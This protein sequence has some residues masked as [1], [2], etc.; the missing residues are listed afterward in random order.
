MFLVKP[1]KKIKIEIIEQQYFK[2]VS[3]KYLQDNSKDYFRRK[4]QKKTF[5]KKSAQI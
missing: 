1:Y 3:S 5:V 4:Y 2:N